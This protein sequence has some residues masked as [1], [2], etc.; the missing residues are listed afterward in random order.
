MVARRVI[1]RRGGPVIQGHQEAI[2]MHQ[3]SILMTFFVAL[4]GALWLALETGMVGETGEAVLAHAEA[5][6]AIQEGERAQ[7]R[8]EAKI[9]A[10][11]LA[12]AALAASIRD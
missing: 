4:M 12:A 8:F 5:P 1:E 3:A 6:A 7:V 10:S 2:V 9:D 11:D